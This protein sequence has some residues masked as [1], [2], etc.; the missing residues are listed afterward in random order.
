[1]PLLWPAAALACG[2]LGPP[3][4]HAWRRVSHPRAS[5]EPEYVTLD[6]G[7][8]MQLFHQPAHASARLGVPPVVFLHGTFHAGWCW[9][10]HW[11]GHFAA[12]GIETYALSLR[13]TSGTPVEQRAV[14]VTQHV[15]DVHAFVRARLPPRA[16]PLLVAHSFGGATV[17]KYLEAGHA[18]SGAVLLCSVPPSGNGPMTL[19]FLRR[20]LRQAFRITRGLAAKSAATSADDARA[21][22]FDA[23]LPEARLRQFMPR[24]QEDSKV[25]LDIAHFT[26]NL[27]SACADAAGRARWLAGMPA[28]VLGAEEDFIVDREGVEETATFLGTSAILLPSLPH[29]VML[30]TRWE[31]AADEIITWIRQQ[32][33]ATG[34]DE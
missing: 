1:M 33:F 17:L 5:I 18:A 27:P 29:D 34:G 7:V 3:P 31:V 16:P 24:F 4:R 15:A 11:M 26:R 21:L 2:L 30:C 23:A 6:T 25:S 22:F 32:D 28:L 10:E 8:T 9:A 13:G 19:R 12:R 20:S 14:Q